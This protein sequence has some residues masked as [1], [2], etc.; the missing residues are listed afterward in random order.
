MSLRQRRVGRSLIG[1][2]AGFLA[3]TLTA[4]ACDGDAR[5]GSG[6]SPLVNAAAGSEAGSIE[7]PTRWLVPP[8]PDL[9][10][11]LAAPVD[12]AADETTGRLLVL[13]L[14]PP[15]LRSYSLT[16]GELLAVMG[17]EGEGPGE[18][19]HPIGAA[20]N[21][22][23]LAAV[24]AVDGR[25]TFWRDDGVPAGIVQTGPGLASEIMAARGDT[26]YVKSDLFPPDDFSE[27]RPVTPDTAL[28]DA[29]YRDVE[30]LRESE[31]S[32][33]PK[34]HAY[35]V[36]ATASGDLLLSPPGPDYFILRVGS[37]GVVTQ[38]VVRREIA[39]LERDAE[40]TE[41]IRERVRRGFAAAGRPPPE[42]IPVP[43]YRP[44]LARLA[45][46]PDGSI[47]GLTHRGDG[48]LSVID[49][50]ASDGRYTATYAVGLRVTDIAVTSDFM[51]LLARSD[52]D[53]YGVAVAKRP[54]DPSVDAASR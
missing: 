45:V 9:D 38:R 25:V 43:R 29:R 49:C 5:A 24:L 22:D 2:A 26:F 13:E 39:P 31:P 36:A 47:W 46:A 20:V 44:H 48:E 35:A 10:P 42:V 33:G 27:F 32:R 1:V 40:E 53:V 18:Y 34:S 30:L 16:S 21:S 4:Q 15:E 28:A 37:G 50:F 8:D 12:I 54:T 3:A 6:S 41:A 14:Q 17:R 19:R 7:L 23:G 52:Y 11:P 51:F